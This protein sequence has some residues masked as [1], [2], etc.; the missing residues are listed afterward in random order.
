MLSDSSLTHVT[1]LFRM[2]D[3]D[4][5]GCL[6]GADLAANARKTDLLNW[7]RERGTEF[8]RHRLL[9]IT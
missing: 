9:G 7:A 4:G 5:D 6:N 3:L 2:Y 1:T 8:A